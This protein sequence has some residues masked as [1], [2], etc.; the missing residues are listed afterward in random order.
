MASAFKTSSKKKFKSLKGRYNLAY[1]WLKSKQLADGGFAA[2]LDGTD[3][4]QMATYDALYLLSGKSLSTFTY[5]LSTFSKKKTTAKISGSAKVGNTLTAKT[6]TTKPA[7]TVSYQWL[8]SGHA[9]AGATQ[10]TY[11]VAAGDAGRRLRVKVTY[12]LVGYKSV[13][14]TSAAKR[15]HK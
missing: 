11:T 10:S 13:V 6:G 8:R 9:I 2:T 5:K 1:K 7:A 12:T 3:S 14:K 15:A 4:D